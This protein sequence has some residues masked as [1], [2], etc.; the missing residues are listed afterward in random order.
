MLSLRNEKEQE[1]MA[2]GVVHTVHKD[3]HWVNEI[4]GVGQ[5]GATYTTKDR[6]AGEGR[7]RARRDSSAHVIHDAE[8]AAHPFRTWL[9]ASIATALHLP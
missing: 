6:A 9:A 5:F 4:E 3:G 7:A 1:Q 8:E 2:N